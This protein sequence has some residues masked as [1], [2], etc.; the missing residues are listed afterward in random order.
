MKVSVKTQTTEVVTIQITTAEAFAL[1]DALAYYNEASRNNFEM[2]YRG[3]EGR[4]EKVKHTAV[5]R[6]AKRL[7]ATIEGK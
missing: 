5:Q 7:D 6:L 1:S 4:E 2:G 3:E